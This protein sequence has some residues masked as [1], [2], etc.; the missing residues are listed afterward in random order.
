MQEQIDELV[1]QWKSVEQAKKLTEKEKIFNLECQVSMLTD[2]V[3]QIVF[4]L[5][6]A[7]IKVS[8]KLID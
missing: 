1:E 3:K 4:E 8:T 7:G 5:N 2:F 6:K